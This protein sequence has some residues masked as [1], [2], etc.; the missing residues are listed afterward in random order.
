MNN[1]PVKKKRRATKRVN[2]TQLLLQDELTQWN[3]LTEE[4]LY[5]LIAI[6]GKLSKVS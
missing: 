6:I 3:R 2:E 4:M 5:L 1:H